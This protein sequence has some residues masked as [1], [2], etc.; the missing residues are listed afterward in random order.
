MLCGT[1]VV[2]SHD[3]KLDV[4]RIN[5]RRFPEVPVAL[6]L[7]LRWKMAGGVQVGAFLGQAL[8][9][10][11]GGISFCVRRLYRSSGAF[12]GFKYTLGHSAARP[13]APTRLR[14]LSPALNRH[15][16]QLHHWIP[17]TDG[18]VGEQIVKRPVISPLF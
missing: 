1:P 2:D 6:Q 13:R 8:A 14:L 3:V 7:V 16:C 12:S 15:L 18:V 17:L 5:D 4:R 11:T 10:A 9:V